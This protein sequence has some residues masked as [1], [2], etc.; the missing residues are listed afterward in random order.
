MHL[1]YQCWRRQKQSFPRPPTLPVIFTFYFHVA[2]ALSPFHILPLPFSG[3]FFFF[4]LPVCL[5]QTRAR[6]QTLQ[7]SEPHGPP[8]LL[9]PCNVYKSASNGEMVHILRAQVRGN[10]SLGS[11]ARQEARSS[12]PTRMPWFRVP[13]REPKYICHCN[14]LFCEW[15]LWTAFNPP[16]QI[17][18]S[19]L[20]TPEV[21][22]ARVSNG[23]EFPVAFFFFF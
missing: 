1:A 8:L 9:C 7:A 22:P 13:S 6:A 4:C 21:P 15:W 20:C 3:S 5:L 10:R 19:E 14:Q 12:I 16:L 17:Q 11:Q 23:K 2:S 18:L